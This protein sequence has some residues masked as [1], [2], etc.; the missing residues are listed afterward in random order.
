[1]KAPSTKLRFEEAQKLLD[2]GFNNFSF[3]KFGKKGDS[4]KH[5]SITK[6][7]P[8]YVE[9]VLENDIGIIIEKRKNQN[10][11]QSLILEDNIT[12]PILVG[13]KLGEISFSLDGKILS[14]VNLVAKNS[15]EKINLFTMSKK[16]YYSWVDLLRS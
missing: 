16:I 6:G 11:E 2:Y 10:I 14:T 1:M 4:I 15:V 12:A 9:A 5:I 3:E 7:I 13:Q 8:T